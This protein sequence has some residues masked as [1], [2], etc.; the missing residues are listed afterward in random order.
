MF[1]V[2]D[3]KFARP[4]IERMNKTSQLKPDDERM[5]KTLDERSVWAYAIVGPLATLTYFVVVLSQL[6]QRPPAEIQWQVPM[7]I[8]IGVIMLGTI[9]GTI[10]SAIATAIATGGRETEFGS[11]IRD[12]QINRYGQRATEIV[13]GLALGA[14]LV[15]AMLDLDTFWIGNA[16]FAMGAVGGLWGAIVKIR[17]YGRSFA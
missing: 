16:A 3:I 6:A 11:D 12:K 14:V 8:A 5:T 7:L 1:A 17:A 15:L 13:S 10:L 4:Y 2:L 9:L